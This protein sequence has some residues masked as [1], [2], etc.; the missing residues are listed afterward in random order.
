M[1]KEK[2]AERTFSQEERERWTDFVYWIR[3]LGWNGAETA[4]QLKI[5]PGYVSE[6]MNGKKSPSA[7]L[8]GFLKSLV[9][10][11][12]PELLSA[13]AT[14]EGGRMIG[15]EETSG[16]LQPL[17]ED[18]GKSDAKKLEE[19]KAEDAKTYEAIKHLI[20]VSHEKTRKKIH[21]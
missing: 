21:P 12:R 11:L 17:K 15:M 18:N 6:L 19:I 9:G 1:S 7:T 4:R 3:A 2:L 20:E 10:N 5:K 8:L 13:G 16:G 14:K